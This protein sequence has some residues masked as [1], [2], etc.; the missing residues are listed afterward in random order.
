MSDDDLTRQFHAL[1]A[2][3]QPG[4]DVVARVNAAIAAETPT[5]PEQP[6]ASRRRWGLAIGA[7]AVVLAVGM[8]LG[9]LMGSARAGVAARMWPVPVV[10]GGVAQPQGSGAASIAA[11]SYANV[12]AAVAAAGQRSGYSNSSVYNGGAVDMSGG[13]VPYGLTVTSGAAVP[14]AGSAGGYSGTNVQVAGID[15][16]DF[17]K[18]DGSYIYVAKG[19]TV[20]VVRAAAGGTHQVAVIDVSGLTT[21]KEALTGPVAGLMIDGTTLIVLT[22]GFE[23]D[24][25]DWTR[26]SAAY[27]SSAASSLKAAF[28]D[29]SDPVHPKYVSQVEQS[30]TYVDSRL[31]GGILYLISSYPVAPYPVAANPL[32]YVPSVDPGTGLG[33]VTVAPADIT[34][35]PGVAQPAY[36]VV[37]ATKVGTRAMVGEQAVLGNTNTV[38]MSDTNL[39]LAASQWPLYAA[40]GTTPTPTVTIPGFSGSFDGTTTE[41]V[42]VAL[43]DGA[44]KVAAQGAVPGF[45]VNQFALDESDGYLRVATTWVDTT[46]SGYRQE[47]S[48]WVLDSSLTVV[49]SILKLA[50]NE[51]IQSVRFAGPVGYVVTFRQRDPLFAIDLSDPKA[52]TI[53]SALKIPG[54][55]TYLHP[56]G[57]NLLLGVG[58]DTDNTGA[59]TGKLKLS[60]FDVAD[61]YNVTEVSTA[62]VSVDATR[63]NT[64]QTDSTDT[65]VSADHKAAFVDDQLGLVGFPMTV[66]SNWTGAAGDWHYAVALDYCLYTWTGTGFTQTAVIDLA[67]SQDDQVS[68]VLADPSTRGVRVGGDFYVV[69]SQ[70]VQVFDMNGY[71][72]VG[73]VALA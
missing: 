63:H 59:Q 69:T 60:M 48:L 3:L 13:V 16:G 73:S 36:S 66:T 30:G 47:A 2:Y 25:A 12:Y 42:R 27:L 1:K 34:I 53:Q 19:T 10:A 11:G 24:T 57:D 15:E 61:P 31:S 35:T 71:S 32:G 38:Y 45:V 49:G 70:S 6:A 17:V 46:N 33:R 14:A 72:K 20:A 9:N 8:V 29:I 44:L 39:Y 28:Y 54:F 62:L 51:Q 40:D 55:S 58:V 64:T 26:S 65:E 5:A 56:Y 68:Q 21:G 43:G 41:I 4:D 52:P 50:D 7:L 22:H 18:T 23:I 37:T 67:S